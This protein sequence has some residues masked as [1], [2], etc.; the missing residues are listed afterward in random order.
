M[1]EIT[2]IQRASVKLKTSVKDYVKRRSTEATTWEKI[3]ANVTSDKRF[4]QNTK[5]S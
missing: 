2:D 4:I 1:R 5:N 3:F